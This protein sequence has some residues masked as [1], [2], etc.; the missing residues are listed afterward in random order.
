MSNATT[1]LEAPRLETHW[2]RLFYV[3]LF[4]AE[5]ARHL[6]SPPGGDGRA[7]EPKVAPKNSLNLDAYRSADPAS[8]NSMAD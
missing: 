4:A 2:S 6:H 5:P 3:D 1:Q 7:S 8:A